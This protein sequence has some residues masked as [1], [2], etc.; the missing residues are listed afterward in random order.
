MCL[1][2]AALFATSGS[3]LAQTQSSTPSE[4][5]KTAGPSTN[6][7]FI[8]VTVLDEKGQPV[9]DLT[10][11]DFRI[12]DD[13]TPK[14]V[15]VFVPLA[16]G[17]GKAIAPRIFILFD[18]L[19][20]SP[21]QRE[22]SS[23]LIARALQPLET[24][25]SVYVYLLTNHG[26]LYNVHDLYKPQ[27]VTVAAGNQQPPDAPWTRQIQPLLDQAIQNIN[28]VR[29]K[30]YQDDGV[31]ATAT[32]M[33]LGEVGDAL[34]KVTGP[35]TIVWI[36]SGAPN[37]VDYRYGCKDVVFSDVAGSYLAGRCGN[38]CVRRPGVSA[39]VDYA[40]FLQHFEAK[41][42]TSDTIVN[43]VSIHVAGATPPTD[44]GRPRDTLQQLAD[45]SGG[46]VYPDGE[47]DD[48]IAQSLQEVRSRYQ[49][50]FDEPPPDG[51]YHK[52]KVEC[53]RSGV[54]ILAPR[55]YFAENPKQK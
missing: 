9:M 42:T 27:P 37:W 17:H 43:S 26:D 38:D 12:F 5:S 22:N 24:G 49:L 23:T 25:D 19:N 54:R 3:P 21:G 50:F 45:L 16:P 53:S 46:R 4:N 51:K 14:P 29:L 34:L 32:F 6:S 18:L 28:A 47:I 55:G 52:L 39:C 48:A 7:R 33:A 31:R 8:N 13:G 2:L 41:L 35:K 30:D 10:D 36:T 20:T 11:P 15:S 44:R 1:C 40:P